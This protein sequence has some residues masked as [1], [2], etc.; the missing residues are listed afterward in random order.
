MLKNCPTAAAQ[1]QQQHGG[2]NLRAFDQ[3]ETCWGIAI[4]LSAALAFLSTP[5]LHRPFMAAATVAAAAAAAGVDTFCQLADYVV[6]VS[7]LLLL[8]S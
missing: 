3:Q 5:L 8:H 6:S 1:Q 2:S 4:A 7:G